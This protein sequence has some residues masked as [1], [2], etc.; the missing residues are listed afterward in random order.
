MYDRDHVTPARAYREGFRWAP[1]V[2]VLGVLAI[3]VITVLCLFAWHVDG[4]FQKASI[5]RQYTNTVDS[6]AYQQSL[7]AE[8]EQHVTN[9]TGPG[10]LAASRASI[11]AA[12]P[13]QAVIAAQE[14]QEITAL[15]SQAVN[16]EPGAAP[17]SQQFEAIVTANCLAGTPVASPPLAMNPIGGL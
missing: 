6:Q 7:L 1:V 14:L 3:A 13:E 16:F 9:I 8:M 11:P 5:Q 17:G 12:S 4:A 2:L 15:C 10:G